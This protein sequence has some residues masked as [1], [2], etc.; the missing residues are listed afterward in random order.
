MN[1]KMKSVVITTLLMGYLIVGCSAQGTV[2][3]TSTVVTQRNR[4]QVAEEMFQERCK[5]AGE[6]IYKIIDNVDGI[7]LMKLRPEKHN[8]SDQFALDDPYGRDLGGKDGYIE[9]FI[10]GEYNATHTGIPMLGSPPRIG[11]HYVEANDPKD[12]KRYRY[13]GHI[14]EP[15]QTNKAYL[16]GYTR[17]VL[18]RSPAS[19]PKPRYGVTYDDISTHEEREYWIAGSS[20]KIIDLQ[21][22]EVLAERIGYMMDQGQG[23]TSGERSPWLLAADHACPSF[24]P[25]H[26]ASAQAYQALD[27]AEKT[28]K[29]KQ[30]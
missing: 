7:F 21:T 15:W 29:P 25:R 14:E 22:N 24:A 11:Y 8:F 16:K 23:N 18:D 10:R 5:K 3:T 17:F 1:L 26:G 28:L 13:T 20:L 9:S 19:G 4:L 6:K 30:D 2:Q 27:L 12:G